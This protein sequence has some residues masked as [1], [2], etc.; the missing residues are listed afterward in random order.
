MAD[1]ETQFRSNGNGF[2]RIDIAT[3]QAQFVKLSANPRSGAKGNFGICKKREP[4]IATPYNVRSFSHGL[5]P[6]RER[7]NSCESIVFNRNASL[8]HVRV[9]DRPTISLSLP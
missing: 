2:E 3:T 7:R 4:R 6:V 5:S 9:L 1:A 8:P